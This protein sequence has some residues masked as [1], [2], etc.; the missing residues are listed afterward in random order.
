MSNMK[1]KNTMSLKKTPKKR[2]E[3][4][5]ASESPGINLFEQIP[6]CLENPEA[7]EEVKK[8]LER[9]DKQISETFTKSKDFTL[10]NHETINHV[11]DIAIMY[12]SN[13]TDELIATKETSERCNRLRNLDSTK[14]HQQNTITTEFHERK[15][16]FFNTT[17]NKNREI[18]R[19]KQI[20]NILINEKTVITTTTTK[21]N[22]QLAGMLT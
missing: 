19:V 2:S 9:F 13:T 14:T 4:P 18:N 1:R 6:T 17:F 16:A 21:T 20:A 5:S 10:T 11:V 7:I 3:R 15:T 12:G 22:R 8:L